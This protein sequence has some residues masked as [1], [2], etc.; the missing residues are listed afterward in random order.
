MKAVFILLVIA[1]FFK[2]DIS[3]AFSTKYTLIDGQMLSASE[4]RKYMTTSGRTKA[5]NQSESQVAKILCK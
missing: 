2:D 1:F 4:C 3:D 5:Y